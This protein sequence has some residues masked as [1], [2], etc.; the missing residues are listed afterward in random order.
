MS[1][2]V[3][4]T[5]PAPFGARLARCVG[6]LVVCGLG[7]A[8][9]V[10]ADIGLAPW[11]VL[12]DGLSE[13]TGMPIGTAMIIVGL[14]LLLIWI[15]LRVRPGLGTIL[16]AVEIGLVVD[17]VLPH[18]PESDNI[19]LRLVMMLAGVAAFGVG[20]GLY[21][22]AGLGPGPRDG[23]M[24]GLAARSRMSLRLVRTAIEVVVLGGGW[25]LGG[26]PGLGT[27]V[28]ALGIGPLVQ[29]SLH[30][31]GMWTRPGERSRSE[32]SVPE[33][34]TGLEPQYR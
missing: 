17:L 21:I 13:R 9:I 4:R 32:A 19:P 30:H 34:P 20:T 5:V 33:P 26:A 8:S 1:A 7:I 23:L 6:G 31:L 27:A 18:L 22:G 3:I 14:A 28:F 2:P 15:P 10:A 11:D 12:H 24:T 16:N 25:L 29:A